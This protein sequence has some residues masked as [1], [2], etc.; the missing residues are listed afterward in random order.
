MLPRLTVCSVKG[1][2]PFRDWLDDPPLLGQ[3]AEG[4]GEPPQVASVLRKG[5][6]EVG[7][8]RGRVKW[9]PLGSRDGVVVGID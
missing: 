8:R 7:I 1:R 6:D 4:S 5:K 3:E 2:Q 9:Y